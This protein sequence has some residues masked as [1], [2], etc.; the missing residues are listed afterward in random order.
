MRRRRLYI[1]SLAL[2]MPLASLISCACVNPSSRPE[3]KLTVFAASVMTEALQELASDFEQAHPGVDV[4]MAYAGSQVLRFQIEKGAPADIFIS[5]HKRHVQ[6]LKK[7]G[8]LIDERVFAHS[9]LTLIVPLDNPSAIQSF[10]DLPKAS[11]LVIGEDN[12]P[13]GLYTKELL[14]RAGGYHGPDFHE[15]VLDRVVSKET[16]VRLVRTKIELGDSDAAIVYRVDTVSSERVLEIPIPKEILVHAD[17]HVATIARSSR[18]TLAAAFINHL[19]SEP[20]QRVLEKH[21][22]IISQ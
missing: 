12:S 14:E 9:P 8:V 10:E 4:A 1:C 2:T 11:R 3:E 13:V 17:Y 15:R 18:K 20:G 5:G 6:V 22:F 21:G 7:E 19:T 16:S